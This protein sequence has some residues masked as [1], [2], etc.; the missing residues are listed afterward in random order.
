MIVIIGLLCHQH[1]F[2]SG[3]GIV[4]GPSWRTGTNRDVP[5]HE[6][7][8]NSMSPSLKQFNNL[9][10]DL[11]F[12][13]SI[14][15]QSSHYHEHEMD[16]RP[17]ISIAPN[18][19]N[20]MID[21]RSDHPH[22]LG[23]HYAQMQRKVSQQIQRFDAFT[24]HHGEPL[25]LGLMASNHRRPNDLANG[26]RDITHNND[27]IASTS[28]HILR[29]FRRKQRAQ[30]H[31]SIEAKSNRPKHVPD[32][33]IWS[34]AMIDL[35]RIKEPKFNK[36]M[37]LLANHNEQEGFVLTNGKTDNKTS[38]QRRD[39]SPITS[40]G[41]VDPFRRRFGD[42]LDR[43]IEPKVKPKLPLSSP[44]DSFRYMID[45]IAMNDLDLDD[46]R[47]TTGTSHGRLNRPIEQ[48]SNKPPSVT[49]PGQ[50]ISQLMPLFFD[51]FLSEFG[52]GSP[53]LSPEGFSL[54]PKSIN[55]GHLEQPNHQFDADLVDLDGPSLL[56]RRLNGQQ[57]IPKLPHELGFSN[58]VTTNEFDS[59]T[60]WPK[61]F[62][63]TDG[64]INLHDFEREKKRSRVKFSQKNG[65]S[66]ALHNIKRDSFLILHGGTIPPNDDVI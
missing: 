5:E 23:E 21:N 48:G 49:K 2:V 51:K 57:P 39:E 56:D 19:H 14:E 26:F 9:N 66:Q 4:G 60:S 16:S 27:R 22:P 44:G 65:K 36:R 20:T 30:S 37:P 46:I 11:M 62:R 7:F 59:G 10:E 15:V 33:P 1:E 3:H 58:E 42:V 38:L 47:T 40:D 52:N 35:K 41:V 55:H 25:P 17:T 18:E 61:I 54:P 29:P 63:F 53:S 8:D 32:Q 6:Q 31:Q 64:R 24:G 12:E 34:N 50:P 13:D 43:P 45:D 28:D